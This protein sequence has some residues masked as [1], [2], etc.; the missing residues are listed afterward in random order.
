MKF[1]KENVELLKNLSGREIS[2]DIAKIDVLNLPNIM[3]GVEYNLTSSGFE[4]LYKISD[5]IATEI[6]ITKEEAQ[7][8]ILKK[9]IYSHTNSIPILESISSLEV[10][11]NESIVDNTIILPVKGIAV[12]DPFKIG[13]FTIFEKQNYATLKNITDPLQRQIIEKSFGDYIAVGT[14]KG[15]PSSCI[16]LGKKVLEIELTRFKAFLPMISGDDLKY[17][18]AILS[19]N[20]VLADTGLVINVTGQQSKFSILT[21]PCDLNIDRI[22]SPNAKSIREHLSFIGYDDLVAYS[23]ANSKYEKSINMA[24]WWLGKQADEDS[25]EI[26]LLYSIFALEK[27]LSKSTSFSSIAA[28]VAEKCAFLLGSNYAERIDIFEK[29]KALYNVRSMLA[30]GSS[31]EPSDND[32]KTA[33][34]LG[35]K[36]LLEIIKLK[37]ENKIST[38]ADVDAYVNKIKFG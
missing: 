38:L 12:Q 31:T 9:V 10:E 33:Y 17:W 18:I 37:R 32:V 16:T 35:L 20:V 15:H 25:K 27:L 22:C 7:K 19:T 28:A 2:F 24:F 34:S 11:L 29:A 21:N 5:Y 3:D 8:L 36:V 23:D 26:R 13:T 6:L 30:H 1:N 14:L 4:M